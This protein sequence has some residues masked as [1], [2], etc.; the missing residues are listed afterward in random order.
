MRAVVLVGGFGTRLRPLTATTPKQ[1]LTVAHRPMI[2][3]AVYHLAQHGVTEV[4]L[5]V[6][7][8]PDAFETAY[9]DGTCAG[10]VVRYA[11]EPEP[12]DTAGAIGFAARHAAIDDTFLACNG[13]VLTDLDIG[14]LVDW[15][16]TTG[17]EATI[18][19]TPVEDPGR[20]GV[21]STDDN[22]RVHSFF[23]KPTV[24]QTPTNLVNAGTY[25][26]EPSVLDR[27][28]AGR[29][30]SVEREVFPAM[31]ANGT[32]FAMA[33]DDY[34]VDAGTPATYL[35]ANLRMVGPAGGIHPD[36]TVDP[37]AQVSGSVVGPGAV[38]APGASVNASL[39]LDGATIGE[40]ARVEGS[41]VGPGANIT[42]G[43]SVTGL[44]VVGFGAV[45]EPGERL[46]GARR[47]EPEG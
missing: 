17:A 29:P 1:M 6:G 7:F 30:A 22:G 46:D 9:P 47:P 5:S 19:L 25:V 43:A 44:S 4:V 27:I 32:L 14:A 11:V 8:Q 13:D 2:E 36:A 21:V 37:T 20:Y 26:L 15:H 23:E 3:H 16:R 33:S 10:A 28:P 31:A 40:N 38:V 18:A 39:V 42:A 12:L 34:W 35:A 45:V 41:I 24:G